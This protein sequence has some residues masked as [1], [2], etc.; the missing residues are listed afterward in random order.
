MRRVHWSDDACLP[1]KSA[2]WWEVVSEF[3]VFLCS[4]TQLLLYL[5]NYLYRNPQVLT[6][7]TFWF[8]L[9]RHC[10]GKEGVAVSC[11]AACQGYTTTAG[12][13]VKGI[14]Q[15]CFMLL[16]KHLSYHHLC[17]NCITLLVYDAATDHTD[18]YYFLSISLH[19]AWEHLISFLKHRLWV[20][21]DKDYVWDVVNKVKHTSVT[22][23]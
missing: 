8:S 19:S 6:L 1:K 10:G 3:L 2:C 14:P 20:S 17:K 16:L 23:D 4:H 13:M 7:F 9:S 21:W 18:K 5:V 15:S 12:N 11:L 22:I